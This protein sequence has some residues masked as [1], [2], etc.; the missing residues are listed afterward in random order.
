MAFVM[1]TESAVIG[2]CVEEIR[3]DVG[4]KMLREDLVCLLVFAIRNSVP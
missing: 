4:R 3:T 1:A 2:E